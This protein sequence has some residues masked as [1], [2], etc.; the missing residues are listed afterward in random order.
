ME[1][2]GNKM[3]IV[4]P[5][6]K[7][8]ETYRSWSEGVQR[9]FK[10]K[11]LDIYLK[12][13]FRLVRKL[14]DNLTKVEIDKVIRQLIDHDVIY[15]IPIEERVKLTQENP[16][17]YSAT[18]SDDIPDDMLSFIDLCDIIQTSKEVILLVPQ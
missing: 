6:L 9:Y 11:S 15:H 7:G 2:H 16:K 4:L 1:L 5:K 8:K 17:F 12:H 13:H 18:F 14:K 3:K 10:T